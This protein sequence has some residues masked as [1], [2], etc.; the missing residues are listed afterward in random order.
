MP[1]RRAKNMYI[2]RGKHVRLFLETRTCFFK[3][4]PKPGRFTGYLLKFPVS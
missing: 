1:E 4:F 2:F 3:T